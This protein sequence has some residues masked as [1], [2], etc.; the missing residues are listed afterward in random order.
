MDQKFFIK[1]IDFGD[2]CSGEDIPTVLENFSTRLGRAVEVL[3][4]T[5]FPFDQLPLNFKKNMENC[6]PP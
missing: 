3:K 5:K 1:S 6:N 4:L 2:D